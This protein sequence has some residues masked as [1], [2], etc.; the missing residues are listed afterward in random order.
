MLTGAIQGI[1][2]PQS[3]APDRPAAFRISNCNQCVD[4]SLHNIRKATSAG[5]PINFIAETRQNVFL[6]AKLCENLITP[7][8]NR[9]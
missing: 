5:K 3:I 4:Q 2:T 9:F 1:L 8:A 6:G 7:R